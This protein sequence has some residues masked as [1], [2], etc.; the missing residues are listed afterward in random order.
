MIK[1]KD[2]MYDKCFIIN[3]IICISLKFILFLII[4]YLFKFKKKFMCLGK[5]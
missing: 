3:K 5:K 4:I 2:G 1:N